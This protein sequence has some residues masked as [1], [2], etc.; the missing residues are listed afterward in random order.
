MLYSVLCVKCLEETAA[1]WV[2][3]P[4]TLSTCRAC[5]LLCPQLRGSR[6]QRLLYLVVTLV[7]PLP[8][9]Y[10]RDLLRPS[11]CVP[12]RTGWRYLSLWEILSSHRPCRNTALPLSA[13]SFVSRS[14][15]LCRWRAA[16]DVT[17][18]PLPRISLFSIAHYNYQSSRQ[19]CLM[20][21][22][23]ASYHGVKSENALASTVG[24]A[25]E[26]AIVVFMAYSLRVWAKFSR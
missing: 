4:R 2:A 16:R 8:I 15:T 22:S 11:Y 3:T 13:S 19:D 21:V 1:W 5:L 12:S 6:Q 9:P 17:V 26:H 25:A 10:P 18:D 23:K 20:M 14:L 7:L 24:F